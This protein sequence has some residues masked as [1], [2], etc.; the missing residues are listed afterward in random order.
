[1]ACRVWA[2]LC[3]EKR[4]DGYRRCRREMAKCAWV[5]QDMTTSYLVVKAKTKALYKPFVKISLRRVTL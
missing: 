5:R 1:M 3:H 2:A 4:V